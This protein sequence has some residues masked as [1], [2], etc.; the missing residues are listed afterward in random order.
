MTR[1]HVFC[2]GQTEETFV[3]EL[4]YEYFSNFNI[5]LNPI[6]IRTSKVG[7][8]GVSTYAKIRNQLERKCKENKGSFITTMLDLYALPEDC[9]GMENFPSTPDPYIKAEHLEKAMADDLNYS[10]FIPNIIIHE[11]EGLL[12]SMP[13]AFK[14]WFGDEVVVNLMNER[15]NFVSP[16]HI[17][18]SYL[19]APS[20]RILKYC[21]GY[22]KIMHGSLIALDVG[23][24]KI[25]QECTHFDRWL[26][27]LE[28]LRI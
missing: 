5:F 14:L 3:R 11:F 2:E 26:K 22:D 28:D 17:N 23:L 25:R 16:E 12:F 13:E 6:I 15:K 27:K 1:I 8:G 4:L 20:K 21:C 10:N 18:D 7:K 19:T 9:P 24:H